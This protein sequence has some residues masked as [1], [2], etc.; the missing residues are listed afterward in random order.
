MEC[1]K[2]T[3]EQLANEGFTILINPCIE[4]CLQAQKESRL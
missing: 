3:E 1:D 4:G 2:L